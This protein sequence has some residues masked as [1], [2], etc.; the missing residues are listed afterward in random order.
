MRR[1][2]GRQI[3]EISLFQPTQA[4][5]GTCLCRARCPIQT[6]NQL[7][8]FR[9]EESQFVVRQLLVRTLATR[10]DNATDGT[11]ARY[12]PLCSSDVLFGR[13]GLGMNA[14]PLLDPSRNKTGQ[15]IFSDGEEEMS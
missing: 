14:I 10:D 3:E 1:W 4:G 11:H 7:R 12:H 9:A 5:S 2:R 13:Q 6:G 15:T 8:Q